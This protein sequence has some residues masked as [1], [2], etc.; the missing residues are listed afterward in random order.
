MVLRGIQSHEPLTA[1]SYEDSHSQFIRSCWDLCASIDLG[2][3]VA[4]FPV[5]YKSKTKASGKVETGVSTGAGLTTGE[6]DT[7]WIKGS[8]F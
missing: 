1:I 6:A 2:I 5:I 4:S 8:Q 7:T 3:E